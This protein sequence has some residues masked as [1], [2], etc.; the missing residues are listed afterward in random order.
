M[1]EMRELLKLSKDDWENLEELLVKINQFRKAY[2]KP[3]IVTSGYRSMQDHLRI[4]ADKGITDKSKIPMQSL[5]LRAAAIDVISNDIKDLHLFTKNNIKLLEDIGLWV[6]D[7]QYSPNWVHFQ[8][9]P[10][11]SG[12]RFFKP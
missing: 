7:L 1:M 6:E 12:Q 9:F 4:Y 3:L 5:H 2:G 10:P 11:K 8:I